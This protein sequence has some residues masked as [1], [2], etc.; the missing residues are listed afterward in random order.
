MATILKCKM[1]GGDIEVNQDMTV[2]TCLYCGSTMTLPRIDSEKKAR[3]F[4]RANEY[5]INCEF[6]KAYDAYKTITEEDEQEAEAYWGMLLSEYGVE[7]VEDPSS[8]KRV[9]TCHRTLVQPI[10]S[11]V[12]YEL[13]RKYA[14]PENKFL[15]QDEAETL[16]K[17]QKKIL[18]ISSKEEPYDVF[19]CYKE[20]DAESGERTEDSV[21]GQEIYTE[22]TRQGVKVFF[23]RI[24][25]ADKLGQDYEPYIFSALKSARIMLVIGTNNTNMSAVWVKN[26]WSRFLSF[27]QEDTSKLIIPVFKGMEA[28]ELPFELTR[29]QGQDYSKIGA[30]QDITH[31]VLKII[32][33]EVNQQKD[34]EIEALI[35][36]KKERERREAELKIEKEMKKQKTKNS[37]R[38]MGIV[39]AGVLAISGITFGIYSFEKNYM[40]FYRAYKSA[41]K[42][43]TNSEYDEAIRLYESVSDFKDSQEKIKEAKYQKAASLFANREYSSAYDIWSEVSDYND[44]SERMKEAK[45][46][47]AEALCEQGKYAEA[48]EAFSIIGD[49]KDSKEKLGSAYSAIVKEYIKNKAYF[50]AKSYLDER[51]EKT[52]IVDELYLE[53]AKAY[54]ENNDLDAQCYNN[55][56][57]IL[58][59]IENK[60][61]DAIN[62]YQQFMIEYLKYCK[63][64]KV[65]KVSDSFMPFVE[66]FE[67]SEDKANCIRTIV[68]IYDN[69]YSSINF[70]KLILCIETIKDDETRSSVEKEVINGYLSGKH[71]NDHVLFGDEYN[72]NSRNHYQMNWI[73][74]EEDDEYFY[75]MSEKT[76]T[77]EKNDYFSAESWEKSGLRSWLNNG[78]M[79]SIFSDVQKLYLVTNL[80][81]GAGNAD[82]SQSEDYVYILSN[83]EIDSL[84]DQ[85]KTKKAKAG[86]YLVRDL[87]D[88]G[89]FKAINSQGKLREESSYY[90]GPKLYPVIKIRKSVL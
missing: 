41:G 58:M 18:S 38:I 27:M 84:V 64:E 45:Y 80:V 26:E 49:Y 5:R 2:G 62:F 78:F 63:D 56:R 31:S 50:Q 81:Q 51:K 33:V 67:E 9:P 48:A 16:D 13:A 53:L 73:V 68:D 39:L 66:W 44:G 89:M 57:A 11:R 3:L 88:N 17:I 85:K 60:T 30:L 79:E 74:Y 71:E 20:T 54:Y 76:V 36:E 6:D 32:N 4:N 29:F 1:C 82:S 69:D 43:L 34:S 86:W 40:S 24:T 59:G 52:S 25:L 10:Q 8:H 14:D 28:Y 21:I 12:N 42:C 23:S 7:Y 46:F 22:L 77:C 72:T 55:T 61:E 15:Y 35:R 87:G 75:L 65:N 19:I 37:F 47:E 90:T 70:S 83:A